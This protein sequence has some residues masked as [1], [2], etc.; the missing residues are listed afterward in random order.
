MSPGFSVILRQGPCMAFATW[1]GAAW[2]LFLVDT[3]AGLCEERESFSSFTEARRSLESGAHRW[4]DAE[5]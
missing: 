3:D 2:S 5:A 4:P 1:T